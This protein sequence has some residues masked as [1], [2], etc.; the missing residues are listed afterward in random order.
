MCFNAPVSFATWLAGMSGSYYLYSLNKKPEAIFY[1]WVVQMQLVEFLLWKNQKCNK[2][3]CAN[4][5]KE[6]DDLKKIGSSSETS[7]CKDSKIEKKLPDSLCNSNNKLISKIGLVVN[8]MEPIVLFGAITIFSTKKLPTII[9]LF[10]I[11]FTIFT[12]FY[13][14]EI[15]DEAKTNEDIACSIVTP[16]SSPHL[17]WKWNEGPHA[18]YYYMVFLISLIILSIYGLENGEFNAIIVILSYSLSSYIYGDT[19]STGAMWCF[20]AAFAPW[21]LSVYYT[22]MGMIKV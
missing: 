3:S 13:S 1:A 6:C 12:I 7:T 19:K 15:L 11:L 17:E 18:I 4:L 5:D 9:I 20:A 8:H 21:I 2:P 22:K 14:K 10:M 16:E